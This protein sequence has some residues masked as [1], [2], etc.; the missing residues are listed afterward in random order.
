[1]HGIVFAFVFAVIILA[2]S[3]F[4]LSFSVKQE[5]QW[6]KT[7]G[8]TVAVLLWISAALVFGKGVNEHGRDGRGQFYPFEHKMGERGP[9]MM[10]RMPMSGR[11][12]MPMEKPAPV[13]APA[14]N[15][16]EPQETVPGK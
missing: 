4:V 16:S 3:F 2:V 8:F 14:G 6:L 15:G 9:G 12:N 10:H 5:A 13:P 11:M 7:F 1:M